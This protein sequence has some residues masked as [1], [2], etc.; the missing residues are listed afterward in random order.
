MRKIL[1]VLVRLPLFP[2]VVLF[3]HLVYICI[4]ILAMGRERISYWG[5]TW[6]PAFEFLV[7]DLSK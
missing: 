2:V 1:R 4:A 3:M 6:G 7:A 5:P